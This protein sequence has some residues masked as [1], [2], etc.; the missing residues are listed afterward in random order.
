YPPVKLIA[1]NQNLR[2]NDALLINAISKTE[3]ISYALA[4]KQVSDFVKKLNFNLKNG[5]KVKISAI[6]TFSLHKGNLLFN[7]ENTINFNADAF[8]LDHFDFP[9][10]HTTSRQI[11]TQPKQLEP[12]KNKR[13]RPALVPLL[14][15]LPLVAAL[16]Y[17]P[18]FFQ[19]NERF[20]HEEQAGISIP[21]KLN[22]ITTKST[23]LSIP[24]KTLEIKEIPATA[25]H[26]ETLTKETKTADDIKAYVIAGSYSSVKSAEKAVKQLT[27]QGYSAY[28]LPVSKGRHRVTIKSYASVSQAL[29]EL[30]TLRQ[31]SN[32][33][34]LWVLKN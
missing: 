31:E 29:S 14:I 9:L 21:L 28:V 17:M 22:K 5:K 16:T 13:K 18:V 11:L 6:G 24:K 10:L 30:E 15:G 20:V 27:K 2:D 23:E 32:N 7:P 3:N 1:F 12:V 4:E 34:N 26:T 33:A 19:T 25:N 8:G